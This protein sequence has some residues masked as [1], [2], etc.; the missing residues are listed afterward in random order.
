MDTLYI[1]LTVVLALACIFMIGAILMQ[2]KRD[3]GFSGQATGAAGGA[4][5]TFY[6]KNKGRTLEGR[7]ERYTKVLAVVFMVL[8]LVISF[9]T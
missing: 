8:S 2:K 5:K 3:A 6:D 9:L 4:D 7:L 1:V